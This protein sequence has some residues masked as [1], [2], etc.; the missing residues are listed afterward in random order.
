MAVTVNTGSDSDP[1]S[2][3]NIPRPHPSDNQSHYDSASD[4]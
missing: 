1:E 2:D 3:D 4:G